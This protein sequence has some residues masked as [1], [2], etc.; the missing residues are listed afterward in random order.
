MNWFVIY[1]FLKLDNL[2]G[3]FAIITFFTGVI[4]I[5]YGVAYPLWL[6]DIHDS[7]KE[8]ARKNRHAFYSKYFYKKTA[9]LIF[10]V[11]L[12]FA[13]FTP[14]TKEFAVIYLLPKIVNNTKVQQMPNK[15]LA[16]LNKKL[17]E[18]ASDLQGKEDK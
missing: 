12:F 15:A 14:T 1:L 16:V 9:I 7:Q 17:D 13:V 8:Q 11:S 6:A 10:F 2:V 3:L 4:I 5:V 18:W